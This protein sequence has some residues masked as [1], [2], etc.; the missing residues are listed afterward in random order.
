M[1]VIFF[2]PPGAG[3][4]TQAVRLSRELDIPHIS[5]GD[6]LR[7]IVKRNDN[8]SE[9]VKTYI[10]NG[11]LV[12]DDIVI[13]ILKRRFDKSD[14]KNGF[15]LDGFPRTIKQAE[16]LDKCLGKERTI[17]KVVNFVT[18]D[19]T[20]INRL[21]G[22][23]VCR[24]CGAN[25]HVKNIPPKK[26]GVCDRC[27]GEL[28]IREDDQEETVRKRLQVYN[29]QTAPL[30]KYYS[31]RGLLLNF[32]GD[33]PLEEAQK[34]LLELLKERCLRFPSKNLKR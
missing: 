31:D 27:G 9:E 25:F 1:Q 17:Q 20:I 4:G 12:P 28:Y 10:K 5:M 22:R 29:D 18:S 21:S 3:K 13:E 19:E 14:C 8:L 11:E 7:K 24:N 2:G 16:A 6:I 34:K 23:Q 32:P 30:I 15:I 26:E 33:L